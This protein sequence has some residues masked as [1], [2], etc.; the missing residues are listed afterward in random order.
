MSPIPGKRSSQSP[1]VH[2][3]PNQKE[4]AQHSAKQTPT[5]AA[6]CDGGSVCNGAARARRGERTLCGGSA[7]HQGRSAG[8]WRPTTGEEQDAN[9]NF[10]WV[11]APESRCSNSSAKPGNH[12][13]AFATFFAGFASIVLPVAIS[14]RRGFSASGT[15]RV[16]FNVQNAVFGF[17][18]R[19]P[20]HDRPDE[21]VS[22]TTG[23]RCHGANRLL[24]QHSSASA[25]LAEITN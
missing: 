3:N 21:S 24:R 16:Q 12:A 15:S 2:P 19:L 13:L 18:P 22:Q 4:R 25:F 6:A 9:S 10:R 11:G 7:S 14:I 5:P 17:S 23:P 8:T 1:R 20:A